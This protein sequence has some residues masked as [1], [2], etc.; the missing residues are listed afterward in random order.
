MTDLHMHSRFSEDGEFTP[1]E[2][3]SM[4]HHAG[5][6]TLALT[7]HDT[8]AGVPEAKAA[9]ESCG[10]NFLT[11]IEIDCC[12]SGVDFHILGYGIDI[13]NDFFA[14]IESNYSRQFGD[15]SDR[16]L[17][18]LGE[19]GLFPKKPELDRIT[20]NSYWKGGYHHEAFAEALLEDPDYSDNPWLKP[21]RKGGKYESNPLIGFYLE[22]FTQGA[23]C[24]ITM[25]FPD[26]AEVIEGIHS[27]GGF[28][29]LA[30]PA[31]NIRSH[32]ELLDRL[33]DLGIDGLEAFSSYH[34]QEQNNFYCSQAKARGLLITAGSDFHGKIKPNIAPCSV[35]YDSKPVEETLKILL[36][37]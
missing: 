35:K 21:F 24:Y 3:I 30:H 7:D 32:H 34:T 37:K 23:P 11:G 9:A 1:S 31:N 26:A 28:A 14:F 5:A 25:D 27:A 15:A 2:L 17:A 16:M 8:V 33:C 19:L 36:G 18:R 22:Y 6:D 13:K 29:I 10:M 20:A 12:L 4:F